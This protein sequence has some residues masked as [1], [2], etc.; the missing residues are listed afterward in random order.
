MYIWYCP[1]LN[2]TLTS[3]E[4]VG[5][6][7]LIIYLKIKC[8]LCM[9][10]KAVN[11][12]KHKKLIILSGCK[13]LNNE[14]LSLVIHA[15][16]EGSNIASALAGF[17]IFFLQ[18]SLQYLHNPHESPHESSERTFYCSYLHLSFNELMN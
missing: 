16:Y 13:Y 12:G 6:V 11:E 18:R 9:L 7:C 3:A 10:I 5:S 15:A 1:I 17:V 8:F 4:A 2:F 14:L